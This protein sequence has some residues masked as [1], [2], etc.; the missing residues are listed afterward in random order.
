MGKKSSLTDSRRTSPGSI[1]RFFKRNPK[2][3]KLVSDWVRM[4]ATG[5]T[6][7]SFTELIRVLQTEYGFVGTRPGL[8][9][10]LDRVAPDAYA[11]AKAR[12]AGA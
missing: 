7:W 2:A 4:R 9:D 3:A 8:N 5:E 11:K 6:E 1:P 12:G 10:H